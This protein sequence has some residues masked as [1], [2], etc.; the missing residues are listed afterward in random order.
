LLDSQLSRNPPHDLR[1]TTLPI[2][3]GLPTDIYLPPEAKRRA[4]GKNQK[5]LIFIHGMTPRG[6]RDERMIHLS[7]ILAGLGLIVVVPRLQEVA[8]LYIKVDSTRRIAEIIKI[9][10][11]DK[12]LCPTGRVGMLAPSFSGTLA[13]STAGRDDV[14]HLLS[15]LCTIGPAADM[16]NCLDFFMGRPD[17][18]PYGYM[19]IFKNFL[20]FSVG[21]RKKLA[22]AMG[23]AAEDDGMHRK[24]QE[25][26]L[27]DFLETMSK[28][29]RELFDDLLNSRETRLEHWAAIRPK[30]AKHLEGFIP[31]EVLANVR[32]PLTLVHGIDDNV[33]APD[34]SELL[35]TECQKLGKRAKLIITPLIS[36]GDHSVRLSMIKDAYDLAG[37][38]G[39]FIENM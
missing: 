36:H 27:P 37:G 31:L 16:L 9:V 1:E 15:S 5:A 2:D 10:A 39:H 4:N 11:G 6:Q 13:L 38:F 28:K 3:E 29:D 8:D 33:I 35:Y 22:Q 12:T 17:A 34:Q 25:R 24:D 21:G 26:L 32:S 18:D 20:H 23:I 30:L 7:R 19:I 14:A